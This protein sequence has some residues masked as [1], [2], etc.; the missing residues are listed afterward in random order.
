M[1]K[2]VRTQSASVDIVA[3]M[4]VTSQAFIRVVNNALRKKNTG[5]STVR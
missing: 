5:I 1:S 3:G 4:T 2:I